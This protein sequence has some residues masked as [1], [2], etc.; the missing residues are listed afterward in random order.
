MA[1]SHGKFLKELKKSMILQSHIRRMIFQ[2]IMLLT[3]F[4]Q[5]KSYYG[6]IMV[7]M[8]EKDFCI[9]ETKN[10]TQNLI[11]LLRFLKHAR[12]Y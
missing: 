11:I 5:I 8:K 6:I 7:H 1:F 9:K 10:I 2:H 12:K 4:K 3:K